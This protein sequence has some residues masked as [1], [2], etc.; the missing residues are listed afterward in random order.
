MTSILGHHI[1]LIRPEKIHKPDLPKERWKVRYNKRP[2]RIKH[3][4]K[5]LIAISEEMGCVWR[6]GEFNL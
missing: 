6:K 5:Q 1:R 2:I 4:L 3:T